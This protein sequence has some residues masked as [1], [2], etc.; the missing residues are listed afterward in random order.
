MLLPPLPLQ[1][2][3]ASDEA[4]AVVEPVRVP[5]GV[6]LGERVMVEGCA[7]AGEDSGLSHHSGGT[8]LRVRR[9]SRCVRDVLSY[10]L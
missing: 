3:C 1:V 10:E 6:P 2:L 9:G 8:Q 5:E 4:H 7:P